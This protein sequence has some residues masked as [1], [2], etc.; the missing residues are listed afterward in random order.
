M[1]EIIAS[2]G[3][4]SRPSKSIAPVPNMSTT[5]PRTSSSLQINKD[6]VDS[7]NKLRRIDL[8][9]V[10]HIHELK[11][12]NVLEDFHVNWLE[13]KATMDLPRSAELYMTRIMHNT[14]S[15]Q[16]ASNYN[17]IPSLVRDIFDKS[18][19]SAKLRDDFDIL[20][21]VVRQRLTTIQARLLNEGLI[22]R[23]H[24]SVPSS[25]FHLQKSAKFK[26][27]WTRRDEIWMSD[28]VNHYLNMSEEDLSEDSDAEMATVETTSVVRQNTTGNHEDSQVSKS[29]PRTR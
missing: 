18:N 7:F 11:T 15:Y 10:K 24:S 5:V 16:M 21:S 29:V 28:F 25:E 27:Y 20:E 13:L 3:T 17:S 19:I 26:V 22:E 1:Q 14:D 9:C 2:S 12:A 4:S 8:R 6:Q 23:S